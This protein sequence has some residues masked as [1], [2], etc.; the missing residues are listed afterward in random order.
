MTCGTCGTLSQE[1]KRPLSA[2]GVGGATTKA[3]EGDSFGPRGLGHA[4]PI[5]DFMIN[6]VC[7]PD[8]YIFLSVK[9]EK[10]VIVFTVF[11]CGVF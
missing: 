3:R 9:T 6:A 2:R 4:S 5:R 8:D 11:A 1:E 10:Q 7:E